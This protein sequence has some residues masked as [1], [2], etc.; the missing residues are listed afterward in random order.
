[1]RGFFAIDP[2]SPTH[3]MRRFSYIIAFISLIVS[4]PCPA[5]APELIDRIVAVIDNQAIL[6]SELNYRLR[7]ELEQQ[8]YAQYADPQRL[9]ALREHVLDDM[10]DE[11]VLVLKAQ[12]DSVQIEV[13]EVEEMLSEQFRMVKS[14]M[15]EA[16]FGEMLGRV[17]L[18]E[19]QLKARYRKEIRH[20]LLYRQM[21]TELAYRLHITRLDIENFRQAHQGRLP[22]QI[23]ISHI[24]IEV[25][26]DEQALASKHALIAEI[27]QK[28]AAGGDFAELARSYSEDPGTASQGGDLGCFG[29]GQLV[30]EFEETAFKLKPGEISEPVLTQYGYHLIRLREKREDSIC[31]SHILIQARTTDTDRE[32]VR[33]QLG[34]LR[35]RALDGEDFALLART[36]SQN[37]QTAM[38]GGLWDIF[39]S[40]Q[41]PTFLE[42]HLRGLSLGEVCAPFFLDD[43]G[44]IL[45]INDDQAT[46][47][48]LI[49]ELRTAD[50]VQQLIDDYKTEI[51]VEKR[52][53]EEFLRQPTNGTFGSI[54]EEHGTDQAAR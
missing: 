11:H 36:H 12:K 33:R 6:W 3:S 27:Q 16:E 32:K 21:R 7:F 28:L 22:P 8:G 47:E 4:A 46:L 54:S 31:A 52:L 2:Y 9:D 25:R 42:P 45:K 34:E 41:I 23:S 53:D 26:P 5:A 29:T 1:M 35:Q 20:R 43:G 15:S 48:S 40:D 10:I 30:P 38:R 17:G 14:S 50:T 19:R 51:H 37:Q 24:N 18:T 49:R 13:S 39:P 44:H